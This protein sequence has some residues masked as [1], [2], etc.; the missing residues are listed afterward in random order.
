LAP[1][2][3]PPPRAINKMIRKGRTNKGNTMKNFRCLKNLAE[4]GF[5]C[6]IYFLIFFE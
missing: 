1:P 2:P 6:I 4:Y 5:V 3:L